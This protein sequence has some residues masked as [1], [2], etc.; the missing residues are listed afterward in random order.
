MERSLRSVIQVPP[1]R[2]GDHG[3][4]APDVRRNKLLKATFNA[5][6]ISVHYYDLENHGVTFGL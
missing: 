5:M 6:L 4:I 1:G 2:N 3:P